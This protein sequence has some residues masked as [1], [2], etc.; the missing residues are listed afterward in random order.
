MLSSEA[1]SFSNSLRI[2][3]HNKGPIR[4]PYNVDNT[5][6]EITGRPHQTSPLDP[7][8]TSFDSSGQLG[9]Y[10]LLN[11][12]QCTTPTLRAAVAELWQRHNILPPGIDPIQRA[13][14]VAIAVVHPE[15]ALVGVSTVYE[16]VLKQTGPAGNQ[17]LLVY[18]YRMFIQPADRVPELMRQV[19]N[20]TFDVLRNLRRPGDPEGLLI[21]SENPKLMR[22]GMRRKFQR[23]GY[24]RIGHND[25]GQ[26]VILR[27]F[28]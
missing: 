3:G 22:P 10:R 2:I 11:V 7:A 13:H 28:D 20:T 27:R 25:Q 18:C 17:D 19:T 21:V 1:R 26:D 16:N 5:V 23:H 24:I 14:Q 8:I 15:R 12:F 9:G 4:R 6:S